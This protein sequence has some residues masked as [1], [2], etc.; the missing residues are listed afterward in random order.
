MKNRAF[1]SGIKQSTYKVMF[2]IELRVGLA[3]FSL[4]LE[5]I[6]TLEREERIIEIIATLER[7][8]RI[9][10]EGNE[11]NMYE[12]VRSETAGDN[13][14]VPIPDVDKPKGSFRNVIAVILLKTDD[15]MY[16]LGTREGIINHL[17]A[18]SE[19]DIC[20]QKFIDIAEV[21]QNK[22][23]CTSLVLEKAS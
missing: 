23:T 9:I 15:N 10:A 11:N 13:V 1:H 22:L 12:D 6:A 16:Q 3:T 20:K 8:E 4:P 19:F 17:Y 14:T 21:T 2:G 18:R 7:E 5:I